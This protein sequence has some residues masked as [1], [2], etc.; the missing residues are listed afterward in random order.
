MIGEVVDGAAG[1]AGAAGAEVAAI[2][3]AVAI[4]GA[5]EAT[6]IRAAI[7]ITTAEDGGNVNGFQDFSAF[8]FKNQAK[9]NS[10]KKLK[11]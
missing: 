8:L 9:K 11:I 2:A 1:I 10:E 3:G 7:T 6:I 5:A 4:A